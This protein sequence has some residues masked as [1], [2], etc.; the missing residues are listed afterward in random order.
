[1]A[2]NSIERL[3]SENNNKLKQGFHNLCCKLDK[4]ETNYK[5]ILRCNPL[6]NS[7]VIGAFSFDGSIW[8]LN[9]Y[10]EDGSD[11]AGPTPVQCNDVELES[12]PIDICI[13]GVEATQWVV[14]DNGEPTSQVFYTNKNGVIIT[15]P[16]SFLK[17]KCPSLELLEP[18]YVVSTI[19]LEPNITT[20]G[21]GSVETIS[22]DPVI[23]E[24]FAVSPAEFVLEVVV[25]DSGAVSNKKTVFSQPISSNSVSVDLSTRPRD[26]SIFLIFNT[27]KG[28]QYIYERFYKYDSLT[29][30]FSV[31]EIVSSNSDNTVNPY[32][33]PVTLS[34]N[35]TIDIA[36]LLMWKNAITGDCIYTTLCKDEYVFAS[37]QSLSQKPSKF[38][39]PIKYYASLLV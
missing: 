37:G 14:K 39:T 8:T 28:Y 18:I 3:L 24:S 36:K 38:N 22:F 11:Y 35:Y 32:G 2:T 4:L 30:T 6:D 10:L 13:N 23:T 26:F 19:N 33:S 5:P 21:V 15:A 17:G 16:V 25:L 9:Y 7:L 12:D 34:G 27:Y 31:T 20:S 1:M 29:S